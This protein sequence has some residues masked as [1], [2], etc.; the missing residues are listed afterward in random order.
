MNP[1]FSMPARELAALVED[2][3]KR[4]RQLV[5]TLD[6]AQWKVPRLDTVNPPLWEIGHVGNF[7]ETFV[8]RL[9]DPGRPPLIENGNELFNSFVIDHDDRWGAPLPD[10]QGAWAYVDRV[11]DEALARLGGRAS[12]GAADPWETYLYLLAVYHEDMHDEAFSYTRQTL[13]YPAPPLDVIEGAAKQGAG[14]LAGDAE[15][16]GGEFLLGAAEDQPFAYDNEKW[17]HPV[18]VAPFRMA[19]AAITQAEFARFVDEGGYG[20]RKFWDYE[21]WRWRTLAEAEHPVYWRKGAAGWER[22]H[23]DAWAPL[24]PHRPVIHVTWYEAEAYCRWAG[25]RLPSEAEWELAASAAPPGN[26][27]VLQPGK[28]RYPWGDEPPDHTLANLDGLRLGCAD[29]AEYPM[30]DSAHGCRQM[31]GNVWEWTASAFYPFPGYLLDHPYKE[32]SAPWFGYRKVLKGGAW[33]TRG[34]MIHNMYRNFFTPDRQDVFAG[35]R[36]C[37]L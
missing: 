28:R 5:D 12:G 22:R 1:N 3:R 32:Y 13:S 26:G 24:E 8:L 7:Y 16:P 31:I 19:R 36:T 14:P 20:E 17:G 25:R 30:G 33:A 21:G 15:I 23:Y 4:T 2:A 9:L 18:T 27:L 29:V 6:D 34:R 37:A 10:R 11:V 35:F